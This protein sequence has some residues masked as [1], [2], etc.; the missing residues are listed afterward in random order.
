MRN[1]IRI[2]AFCLA[3]IAP[4]ARAYEYPLQFTPN[5]GYRGLVVAGYSFEGAD[6]VGTCSYYNVSGK[7]GGGKGGGGPARKGKVYQQTCQ[8][9]RYGNL[10]GVHAG[11]PAHPTSP[12]STKG[13][14]VIYAVDP[15]NG[16]YTGTD[17]K[18]P[19]HGFVN[20]P[21][22]HYT[23]LTPNVDAVLQQ[24]VYTDT[25]YLKSDGD[26][27]VNITHVA[28]SALHGEVTLKS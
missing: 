24:I 16:D 15:A 10:L 13:T 19:E 18:L 21:G 22:P 2:A 28:A 8:W 23:W 7:H 3:V 25:F 26:L 27:P 4:M 5:P 11:E 6:V 1:K 20:T 12:V 17:A 14:L 9:D